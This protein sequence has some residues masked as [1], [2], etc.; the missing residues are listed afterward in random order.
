MG[1]DKSKDKKF[2]DIR[3]LKKGD[4]VKIKI[5]NPRG[6]M[7]E[8]EVTIKEIRQD[9]EKIKLEDGI[10]EREVGARVTIYQYEGVR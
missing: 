6:E 4:K 9:T 2:K 1:R 8:R 10:G 3:K 5:E 7:V